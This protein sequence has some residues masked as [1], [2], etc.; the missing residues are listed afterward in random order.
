[1]KTVT[2]PRGW[3][4]QLRR[5]WLLRR[6]TDP[7][8]AFVLEPPPPDEW[9]ALDCETTGLNVRSDEIIAIG[10]VR[11]VGNRILTSERLELLVRPDK[12]VPAD[13]VRIH[14]LRSTDVAQ[15]LPIEEALGQLLRFI[16]SRPLVGYYLEFDVAML[17]RALAPLLGTGLPQQQVEISGMYYDYKL[18]QIQHQ[19]HLGSPQ[20]DLRFDTLMQ[21]LGLPQ[22]DA[23]DALNDAVM[24]ALA[25]IK[26]RR[27]LHTKDAKK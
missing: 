20:I 17:N 15:G 3:L 11:I 24:A 8:Y 25:F 21:D 27:L 5:Q 19:A 10:A 2:G 22:R 1:M 18:A 16:G 7:A 13:S 14:R 6:L 12:S 23:H 9:V 26:L 4:A